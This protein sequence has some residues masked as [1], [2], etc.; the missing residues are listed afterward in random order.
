M[1]PRQ[2][3]FGVPSV[4]TLITAVNLSFRLLQYTSEKIVRGGSLTKLFAP[5]SPGIT[6]KWLSVVEVLRCEWPI[7]YPLPRQ[8]AVG[9]PTKQPHWCYRRNTQAKLFWQAEA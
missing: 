7:C 8:E 3:R 5:S 2:S 1:N 6:G 4:F 9:P